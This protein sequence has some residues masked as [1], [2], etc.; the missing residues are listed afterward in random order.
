M[1]YMPL[2]IYTVFNVHILYRP[3]GTLFRRI[4]LLNI[5]CQ[6]GDN[7]NN[8]MVLRSIVTYTAQVAPYRKVAMY[9]RLGHEELRKSLIQ[10]C[11]NVIT[12]TI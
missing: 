1:M 4:S 12:H 8:S 11:T 3:N 9:S 10:H 5:L 2:H 7:W 6:T